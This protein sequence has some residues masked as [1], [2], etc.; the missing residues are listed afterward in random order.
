MSI[1][2]TFH[3]K[4]LTSQ[5][6]HRH[7]SEAAFWVR[8]RRNRML[9]EWVCDLTDEDKQNYLRLLLD[10]DFAKVSTQ[11]TEGFLLLKIRNDLMGFGIFL[12]A[13]E[14]KDVCERFHRQAWLD[15]PSPAA[16]TKDGL[17]FNKTQDPT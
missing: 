1:L 10:A 2:E 13:D 15:Q 5:A 17:L 14:M 11:A 3:A 9:A 8:A 7:E 12:P 6:A 16:A 4:G